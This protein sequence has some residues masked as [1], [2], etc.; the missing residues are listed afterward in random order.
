[1]SNAKVALQPKIAADRANAL[2]TDMD[3]VDAIFDRITTETD[4]VFSMLKKGMIEEASLKTV[5][6]NI[7]R[8]YIMQTFD[9]IRAEAYDTSVR[10]ARHFAAMCAQASEHLV[11]PHQKSVA[12]CVAELFDQFARR[13]DAKQNAQRGSGQGDGNPPSELRPML[14]NSA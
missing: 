7:A 5:E 2:S 10:S 9:E 4:Q 6:E 8:D 14:E 1:M 3:R 12:K 11:E 13:L